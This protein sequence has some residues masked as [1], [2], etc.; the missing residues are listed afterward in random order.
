M[1]SNTKDLSGLSVLGCFAHP[2]DEGFGSGGTLAML[3]D[4]GARVTLVC[5]TNGDV[6]EISDPALAT[7]KNLYQVRQ[8]EL[9]DAMTVTGV[10]DVR[11]LDYR[12][13]G[14]DGTSDNNHPDSLYQ[15]QADRVAEI[16]AEIM[17]E[18]QPDMVLTHDPTGGY[19]HPD[20][21]KVYETTT[22]AFPTAVSALSSE[23]YSAGDN[24]W[25]PRRLYYVCFPR[26]NFRRMW[27]QMMDL[28]LEPPFAKEMADTI[29]SPDEAVT[30]TLDVSAYVDIKRESLNR[31]RTQMRMDGAFAKMPEE[32]M[33]EIMS[34]EYFTLAFP[35]NAAKTDDLL[36]GL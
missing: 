22:L 26:S 20:H 11:F 30:T 2:D 1:V 35:E 13:S 17:I 34:T 21:K 25:G 7:P 14:M 19:G 6:G 4:R 18:V 9:R 31:H 10:Q 36:A 5:A 28:G 32:M 15:A 24:P 3:V 33:R 12:D 23:N 8:E 16:L 29:G 27:Q